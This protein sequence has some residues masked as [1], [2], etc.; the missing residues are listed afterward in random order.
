MRP[1]RT[2]KLPPI[3]NNSNNAML[4][5][6]LVLVARYLVD[7]LDIALHRVHARLEE[8]RFAVHR[9]TIEAGTETTSM[10]LSNMLLG[11]LPI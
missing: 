10:Q 11:I 9:A 8:L 2:S 5:G 3:V 1:N 4:V 7:E 6:I